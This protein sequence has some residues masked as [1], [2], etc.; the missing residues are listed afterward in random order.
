MCSFSFWR[1]GR[2]NLGGI[3]RRML[4]AACLSGF[5]FFF[6]YLPLF[7]F[8]VVDAPDA[9]HRSIRGF[10]L[11]KP[12]QEFVDAEAKKGEIWTPKRLIAYFVDATND[13]TAVW[14][15]ASVYLM[16]AAL[17]LGW[18]FSFF[19]YSVSVSAFVALRYRRIG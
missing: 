4:L 11:Q 1:E 6:V 10:T 13:E 14:T 18:G 8:F 3:K 15:P 5:L 9:E 2:S 19:F 7:A 17:L 16:R 12:I